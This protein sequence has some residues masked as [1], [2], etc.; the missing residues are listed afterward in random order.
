MQ[1]DAYRVKP[2]GI[3]KSQTRGVFSV[4]TTRVTNV[5]TFFNH[6][7]TQSPCSL[8]CRH[9]AFH[10]QYVKGLDEVNRDKDPLERSGGVGCKRVSFQVRLAKGNVKAS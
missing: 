4:D 2:Y 1:S 8:R 3:G 6:F 9:Q 10:Y 5:L 7:T